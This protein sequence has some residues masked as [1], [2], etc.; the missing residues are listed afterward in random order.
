ADVVATPVAAPA[1]AEAAGDSN[2]AA[3]GDDSSTSDKAKKKGHGRRRVP[4]TLQR[5]TLEYTLA[6][7]ERTCSCG[8]VCERIGDE[9]SEQLDW[10]PSSLVVLEHIR[11]KYACQ[12]CE[13]KVAIAPVPDQVIEK[14]LAGTGLL[15]YVLTSKYSDHLPLHRL[16]SIFKRH[17]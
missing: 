11:V 12:L 4:K 16:E 15:S 3:E 9:S 14:G 10:V 13:G 6:P 1:A 7:E 5:L 2:V 8:Q 17:G